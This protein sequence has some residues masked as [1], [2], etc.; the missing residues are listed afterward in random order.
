MNGCSFLVT[1]QIKVGPLHYILGRHDFRPEAPGVKTKDIEGRH[2]Q[3]Q[4]NVRRALRQNEVATN[5]DFF[6][7]CDAAG[8]EQTADDALVITR[9]R[10]SYRAEGL[11][12]PLLM[13]A[14]PV[15]NVV[16]EICNLGIA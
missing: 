1:R 7:L 3:R 6:E 11:A 4:D 2:G 8:N 9:K 5:F 15:I 14:K 10:K 13:F 12:L 16:T